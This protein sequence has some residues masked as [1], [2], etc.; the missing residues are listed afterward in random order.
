MFVSRRVISR[1][2]SKRFI[3]T[4]DRAAPVRIATEHSTR[5]FRRLVVDS[6]DQ[7]AAGET[8]WSGAVA[9][10]QRPDTEGTQE[11]VL[12]EHVREHPAQLAV[13]EQGE[14]PAVLVALTPGWG[15]V[16]DQLGMAARE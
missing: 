4:P 6:I 8:V 2:T 5:R 13:V 11:L 15:N 1:A 14:E 3:W 10:G 9:P 16:R 12:V 7:V